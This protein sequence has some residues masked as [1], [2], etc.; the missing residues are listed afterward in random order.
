MNLAIRKIVEGQSNEDSYRVNRLI[1]HI[2]DRCPRR[3]AGS[4]SEARALEI[5]EKSYRLAGAQ[6]RFQ[7]F[8]FNEHLYANL[9]LHFGLA[10]LASLIAFWS[11]MTA[12]CLHLMVAISYIGDTQRWFLFLRRLFPF[13]DSRNLLATLPASQAI[14]QRIVLISHADAAFTGKVFHPDM[15]RQSLPSD[16]VVQNFMRKSMLLGVVTILGLVGVETAMLLFD[17]GGVWTTAL[18]VI[19]TLPS[20]I[21]ALLN[22][23]VVLRDEVVPGANDNL[24]GCAGGVVLAERLAKT[25]P[26]DVEIV[27]VV[28]GCEEAGTGGSLALAKAVRE[29]LWSKD[30]TVVLAIDGLS[31]G[32]LRYFIDGELSPIPI[33]PWLKDTIESVVR[34]NPRYGEVCSYEIPTGGTDAMPFLASGYTGVGIGCIDPEIGAPRHY[35]LPSDTPD[36]LDLNQLVFSIDFIEDLV[37]ALMDRSR[38]ERRSSCQSVE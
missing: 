20:A 16:N 24:S 5:L 3:V 26:D 11:P 36:N 17:V 7:D 4:E 31:N 12:L 28:T 8:R 34:A 14:R 13:V 23:E 27:F 19:L 38:A 2:V 22:I 29:G 32:E 9:A 6:V 18:I 35:H 25:K 21:T 15:V 30:S 33:T 10:T 37:G 1:R